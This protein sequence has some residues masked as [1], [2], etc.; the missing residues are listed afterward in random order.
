MD[1]KR[2]QSVLWLAVAVSL[3]AAC[4]VSISAFAYAKLPKIGYID[5]NVLLH[6]HGAAVEARKTIDS[7]IAEWRKNLRT[8]EIELQQS[9]RDLEANSASMNQ[10]TRERREADLARRQEEYIRYSKTVSDK[11]ATI[12]QDAMRPV[13]ETLNGAIGDF[14]QDRGYDLI[15]GTVSGGNVLAAAPAYDLTEAFLAYLASHGD[16]R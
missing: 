5:S 8:L 3:L 14:R 9:S 15:F 4:A 6:R 2:D 10:K 1:Q 12:E 16:S 7:K 13:F 11:L